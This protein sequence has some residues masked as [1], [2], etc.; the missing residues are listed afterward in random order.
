MPQY[1]LTA[2]DMLD[3]PINYQSL[4]RGRMQPKPQRKKLKFCLDLDL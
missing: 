1:A 3:F 2:I 4:P